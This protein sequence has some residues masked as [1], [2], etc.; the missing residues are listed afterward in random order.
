MTK[1]ELSEEARELKN[2]YFRKWR[3]NNPEKV[4]AAKKRY[5]EKKVKELKEKKEA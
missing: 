2:E 4:A 5:W 1:Y 3:K